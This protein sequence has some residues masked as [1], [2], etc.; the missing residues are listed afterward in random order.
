MDET[1]DD[2]LP[3]EAA[4]AQEGVEA[5]EPQ[6]EAQE[7]A[8]PEAELSLSER[9]EREL[10][11]RLREVQQRLAAEIQ[12]VQAAQ[13]Y[14]RQ[15]E[16]IL[17]LDDEEIGRRV[18]ERLAAL[19]KGGTP[20]VGNLVAPQ[21]MPAA[22]PMQAPQPAAPP[23]GVNIAELVQWAQQ[24]PELKNP[25]AEDVPRLQEIVRTAINT[26]DAA[27]KLYAYVN[28]R[29]RAEQQRRAQ[30]LQQKAASMQQQAQAQAPSFTGVATPTP[31]G[32]RSLA[33]YI[34]QRM[35]QKLD[36]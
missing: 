31:S 32:T 8:Q 29:R 5:Q 20:D 27:A 19:V 1:R 35:R 14:R 30:E 24:Y 33:E 25:P 11:E 36:E 23:V 7:Q 21:P 18:K 28:E 13:E 10:N 16:E 2:Q 12:K 3:E 17:Q 34:I 22:Q 6:P 15:V 4:P 9:I 26:A